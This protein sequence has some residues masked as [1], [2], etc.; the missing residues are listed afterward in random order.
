MFYIHSKLPIQLSTNVKITN[1]L[2][3]GKVTEVV[4]HKMD[5]T[6]V[7]NPY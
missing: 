5:L 7:Y 3:K 4:D 2:E 1:F 6:L